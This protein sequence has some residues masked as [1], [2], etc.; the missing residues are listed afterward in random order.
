[1]ETNKQGKE[2]IPVN[3]TE[4]ITPANPKKYDVV[5]AFRD[6]KKIDWKQSTNVKVGDIVYI[7]VSAPVQ[8]VQFKCKVN[9]VDIEIP[10]I[11]PI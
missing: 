4:W 5:G 3:V 6:L 9:K 11:E 2:D 8:A 10:D 1:M 7:Y